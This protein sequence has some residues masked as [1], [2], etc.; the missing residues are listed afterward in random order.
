MLPRL[1]VST[2]RPDGILSA[3]VATGTILDPITKIDK[4]DRP[5]GPDDSLPIESHVM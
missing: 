3:P 2:D 4:I 5:L 1:T